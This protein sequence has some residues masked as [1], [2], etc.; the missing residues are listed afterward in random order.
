MWIFSYF[1]S[2]GKVRNENQEENPIKKQIKMHLIDFHEFSDQSNHFQKFQKNYKKSGILSSISMNFFIIFENDLVW[3]LNQGN[4]LKEN[5]IENQVSLISYQACS[6]LAECG[7][8]W[9]ML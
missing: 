6:K 8:K 1:F 3:K 5:E 2:K 9:K 7:E 4:Q